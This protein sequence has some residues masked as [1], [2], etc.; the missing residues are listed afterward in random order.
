MIELDLDLDL[1]TAGVGP[2]LAVRVA[3]GDA[4]RLE[5][6]DIAARFGQCCRA[7]L[8]DGID[9]RLGAA[10]QDRRLGTVNFDHAIV[11]AETPERR[12]HVLCG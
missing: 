8:I 3:L 9:E 1:E 7:D 6:L 10:V 2:Q 4:H 12:Q 11:D 5:D